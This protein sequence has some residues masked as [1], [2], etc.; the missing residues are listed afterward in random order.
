MVS[1]RLAS[2][3]FALQVWPFSS[4]SLF[5][6]KRVPLFRPPAI[7]SVDQKALLWRRSS[8]HFLL[9]RWPCRLAA[10]ARAERSRLI[11]YFLS[12]ALKSTALAHRP[13][14]TRN[15]LPFCRR[16][17]H[18]DSVDIVSNKRSLLMR[19][20]QANSWHVHPPTAPSAVPSSCQL[21]H[22]A[23]GPYLT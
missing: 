4:C 13:F 11:C 23:A 20:G 6:W 12:S 21:A 3:V 9:R 14:S 22:T 2:C 19:D 15:N 5:W 8:V 18:F 1:K 16:F 10:L 17:I 7:H